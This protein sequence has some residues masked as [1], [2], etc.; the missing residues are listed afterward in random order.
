M[1]K[2][3]IKKDSQYRKRIFNEVKSDKDHPINMGID[4]QAHHLISEKGAKDSG[5][6]GPLEQQG[7]NI[8]VLENLVLMPSTLPG[9]CQLGVQLHRGDHSFKDDD[10]P[11]S[12]HK[13]ITDRVKSLESEMDKKCKKKKS[14][15]SLLDKESVKI[16]FLINNFMLPLT[17]IYSSFKVSSSVGCG[18][19]KSIT[20]HE[21]S[22]SCRLDRNHFSGVPKCQ[23]MLEVGK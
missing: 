23:Y 13:K 12:Y 7:F 17:S 19:V 6:E 5:L 20:K 2:G 8:N 15:Q 4:M 9:A 18:N 10:H 14:I 11:R 1:V 3:T 16:L 21:S 22:H